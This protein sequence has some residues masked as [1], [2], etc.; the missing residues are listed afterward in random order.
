MYG[1]FRR[2]QKGNSGA[3]T[4]DYHNLLGKTPWIMVKNLVPRRV[5]S[6]V[7]KEF[8]A[9]IPTKP[10]DSEHMDDNFE[11]D[12]PVLN[13]YMSPPTRT[14]TLSEGDIVTAFSQFG[15]IADVRFVRH[16]K[17]GEFLGTAFILYENYLS[18]IVAADEMNSNFEDGLIVV[19]DVRGKEAAE[20]GNLTASRARE[21]GIIVE[22]C[23]E[24]EIPKIGLTTEPNRSYIEWAKQRI[25]TNLSK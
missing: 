22:R 11:H 10:H 6:H 2:Y 19:L 14:D 4:K 5:S 18:G 17:T 1:S 8:K 9:L 12:I 25:K 21:L 20:S 24:A 3:Y 16:R 15:E 13:F 7:V 23:E